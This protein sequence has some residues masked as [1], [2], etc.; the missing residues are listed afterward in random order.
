MRSN[1][2][3][4]K[5]APE[6]AQ[7]FLEELRAEAP[8]TA[9]LALN[10]AAAAFKLR[11]QFLKKQPKPRQAEWMRKALARSIAAP[12]AEEILASYFL[13]NHLDLLTEWLDTA[14]VKHEDGTLID[15]DPACPAK[16]KLKQ[17]VTKFRKGENPERRNLL[18]KAFA[19]QS[20][21]DWPDLDAYFDE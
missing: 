1:D 14:G 20:A 17:A 18:L 10:A 15:E 21:I 11:P 19:S 12:A 2:V 13:E 6:E 8:G 7:T 5:M 4:S 16:T 3:F 9:A